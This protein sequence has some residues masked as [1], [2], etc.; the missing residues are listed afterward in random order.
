MKCK[1]AMST[2][3]CSLPNEFCVQPE[4][5]SLVDVC[6]TAAAVRRRHFIDCLRCIEISRKHSYSPKPTHIGLSWASHLTFSVFHIAVTL[7]QGRGVIPPTPP[8]HARNVECNSFRSSGGLNENDCIIGAL[9][10]YI[11]CFFLSVAARR[12]SCKQK[13]PAE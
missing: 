9:H 12:C 7:T 6:I 10:Y 2:K 13:S 11:A 8:E 3:M 4:H 5:R 1:P